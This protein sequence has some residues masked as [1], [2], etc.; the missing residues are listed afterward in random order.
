MLNELNMFLGTLLMGLLVGLVNHILVKQNITSER[1]IDIF[2]TIFIATLLNFLGSLIEASGYLFGAIFFLLINEKLH[3]FNNR[4]N[5][6]RK[7]VIK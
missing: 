7:K 2:C 6:R 5:S 3:H 1:V 4:I